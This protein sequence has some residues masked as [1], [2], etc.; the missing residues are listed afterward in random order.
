MQV[1]DVR[2]E[3]VRALSADDQPVL[4]ESTVAVGIFLQDRIVAAIVFTGW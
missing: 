1:G 2:P 3:D 4:D